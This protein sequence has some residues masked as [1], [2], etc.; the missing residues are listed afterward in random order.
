MRCLPEE[1]FK[2]AGKGAQEVSALIYVRRR[3][4]MVNR[5]RPAD[6]IGDLLERAFKYRAVFRDEYL[7]AAR[8]MCNRYSGNPDNTFDAI[9]RRAGYGKYK[10]GKWE[11][12]GPMFFD[13]QHSQLPHS[14]WLYR[15]S[16]N[17]I[18][19]TSAP[20]SLFWCSKR[21][22]NLPDDACFCQVC[23][24]YGTGKTIKRRNDIYG[25][26]ADIDRA[27]RKMSEKDLQVIH[28]KVSKY[29]TCQSCYNKIKG[30]LKRVEAVK[31]TKQLLT[32][33][34]VEIKNGQNQ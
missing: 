27:G 33:L 23:G 18:P 15:E 2:Q 29:L 24:K 8:K 11:V 3:D 26:E 31:Q 19:E 17:Y 13:M 20:F 5:F 10:A 25:W 1:S 14:K 32:N 6:F 12:D 9:E 7:K 28:D 4:Y 34:R 30:L 22:F 21:T 16:K